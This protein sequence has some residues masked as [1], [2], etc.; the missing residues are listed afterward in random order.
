MNAL[1]LEGVT[2]SF[3]TV[4]AVDNLSLRV[5][6]GVVYGLLGP[7][8]AG[9]TTTIRIAMNIIGHDAGEVRVLGE[10]NRNGVLRR[11]GY[12]PEE[13][14]LYPKLPVLEILEM[15]GVLKGMARRD[16]NQTA[17]KW[18]ERF[19]LGE[20]ASR[21]VEEL[22][23]GMQQKVMFVAAVLNEPELVIL[24]EPFSGLDPVSVAETKDAMLELVENGSTLILSTHMMEQ[25][26]KLCDEICLIN[27]GKA[28]L[29][30]PLGEVKRDFGEE[31]VV[32]AYDGEPRFLDNPAIVASY[33]NYGH[34][35]EIRPAPGVAPQQVLEAALQDVVVRRFE[36]REPSLNEIFI[37]VVKGHDTEAGR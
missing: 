15:I 20:W 14:G 31:R 36:V 21:R 11:V 24:D 23:K 19:Q 1:E 32:L 33:D 34:Y 8:G 13:R 22:S 25:V 18:L 28:V 29:Q 2:K 35:V 27:H 12:L 5:R 7:N 4:R 30:G 26:E 16:A 9:K 17:R 10:P 3:G 6:R 37:R